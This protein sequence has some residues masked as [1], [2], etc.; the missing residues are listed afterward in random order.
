MPMTVVITTKVSGRVRGFLAS[1]MCELAPGVYTAPRMNAAVRER[2]WR[3][4][5]GWFHD[6]KDGSIVMTWPHKGKLGGQEVLCLGVPPVTLIELDGI[7][8]ARR[9]TESTKEQTRYVEFG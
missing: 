9:D 1:C 6:F 8:L 4:M 3:V 2:V 7:Y 5:E